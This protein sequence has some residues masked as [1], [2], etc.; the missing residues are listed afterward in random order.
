MPVAAGFAVGADAALNPAPHPIPLVP[1]V[2]P[3]RS[4]GDRGFAEPMCHSDVITPCGW[5]RFG[6]VHQVHYSL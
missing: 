3:P 4:V 1:N 5:S 6:R 2:F